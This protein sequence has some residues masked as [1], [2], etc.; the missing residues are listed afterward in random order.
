MQYLHLGNQRIV[1]LSVKTPVEE[2]YPLLIKNET[3]AFC[4]KGNLFAYLHPLILNDPLP[5]LKRIEPGKS[6]RKIIDFEMAKKL[7][8]A[9]LDEL[10]FSIS[11][12]FKEVWPDIFNSISDNSSLTPFN[13]VIINKN[14]MKEY[15]SQLKS[16]PDQYQALICFKK[17]VEGGYLSI[18]GYRVGIEMK[19]RSVLIMRS[20][21]LVHGVT[22]V[23]FLKKDSYRITFLF[24]SK[25]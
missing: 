16:K 10:C 3:I 6:F 13:R 8:P 7:P 17:D 1:D 14:Y 24:M 21:S 18:P 25:D 20:D 22:P 11:S 9:P 5:S 12:A 23:K 19:D 4:D 15:H 2:D